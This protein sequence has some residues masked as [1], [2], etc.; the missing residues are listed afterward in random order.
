MEEE[1]C[2]NEWIKLFCLRASDNKVVCLMNVNILG[3]REKRIIIVVV[4][5]RL[6][7]N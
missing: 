3:E 2:L 7:V 4:I 1:S 5:Y 6:N